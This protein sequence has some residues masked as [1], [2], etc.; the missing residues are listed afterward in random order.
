[1]VSLLEI[2]LFQYVS[3]NIKKSSPEKPIIYVVIS[4]YQVTLFAH[5]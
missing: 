5:I 4:F 2:F 1:M 3:V